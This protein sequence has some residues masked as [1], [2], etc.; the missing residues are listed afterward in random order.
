MAQKIVDWNLKRY[1]E[2]N[3]DAFHY[4]LKFVYPTDLGVFFLIAQGRLSLCVASPPALLPLSKGNECTD[5][6][7]Q[8]TSHLVLG[9]GL[10]GISRCGKSKT[11]SSAGA[12]FTKSLHL[13]YG[14]A[15]LLIQLGTEAGKAEGLQLMKEIP[16][17]RQRI[18]GK[19]IPLE[20]FVARKARRCESQGGRLLLSGLELAYV[21]HAVARAPRSVI[22]A[23]MLPLVDSALASLKRH[24]DARRRACLRYIAY[25]DPDALLDPDEVVPIPQEEAAHRSGAAFRAVFENG[26]NIELEHHI[27][28]HSHYEYGR[29][30]ACMGDKEGARAQFDLVLSVNL[31]SLLTVTGQNDLHMRTNAAL[32]S[33]ERG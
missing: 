5:P 27:V 28:Y 1:P 25:P 19:S 21:F 29:L 2:G 31:S 7:S 18:A 14:V 4:R 11:H 22:A 9:D 8:F 26:P 24:E 15:A 23:R 32:E 6:I 17:L 13:C 3:V 20:K 33:L 30:L 16:K 12:V 10:V